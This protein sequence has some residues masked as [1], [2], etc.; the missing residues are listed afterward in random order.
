[1]EIK[2]SF[3]QK[4]NAALAPTFN[5]DGVVEYKLLAKCSNKELCTKI[6]Y[7]LSLRTNDLIIKPDDEDKDTCG[8][9]VKRPEETLIAGVNQRLSSL[10]AE[11]RKVGL[12]TNIEEIKKASK[13]VMISA[14]SDALKTH[15]MPDVRD[16]PTFLFLKLNDIEVI[17]VVHNPQ[18]VKEHID[19][20]KKAYIDSAVQILKAVKVLFPKEYHLKFVNILKGIK[21]KSVLFK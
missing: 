2:S 19:K 16:W 12:A 6:C 21:I 5:K 20:F 17:S 4:V 8:L 1:M 11:A 15:Y 7:A 13:S 14:I 9:Y 18:D 3:L 10:D